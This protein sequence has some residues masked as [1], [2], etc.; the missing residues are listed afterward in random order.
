MAGGF[1]S[2]IAPFRFGM[3]LGGGTIIPVQV[4]AATP[5]TG[6]DLVS[7]LN[8]RKEA[9]QLREGISYDDLPDKPGGIHKATSGFG[10]NLFQALN[11]IQA[12]VDTIDKRIRNISQSLNSTGLTRDPAGN[13]DFAGATF[14]VRAGNQNFLLANGVMLYGL[15]DAIPNDGDIPNGH[16]VGYLDPIGNQLVFRVRYPDGTLK[17]GLVALI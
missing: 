16:I 5:V 1:R 12:H 3:S 4:G 15:S 11:A 13:I 6:R 10:R 17:V 2:Y 14:A 9:Q 8:I 7:G